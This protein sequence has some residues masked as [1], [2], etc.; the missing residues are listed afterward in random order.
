MATGAVVLAALLGVL[1]G[2]G[3]GFLVGRWTCATALR[4]WST[5]ALVVVVCM[6]LDFAGLVTGRPLLAYGS[7][8]L[9]GGTLWGM[10]FGRSPVV[11]ALR[12]TGPS[13]SAEPRASDR[14]P[15]DEA[16]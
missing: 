1:F 15:T 9:M 10:R 7:L 16:S 2:L 4:Y 8:G 13:E 6:A 11:G 14:E 5:T 12:T 3:A